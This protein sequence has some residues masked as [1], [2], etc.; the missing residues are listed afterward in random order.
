ML[1]LRQLTISRKLWLL[2]T[3]TTLGLLAIAMISLQQNHAD[4]LQEKQF[5][6]RMLVETAHSI[7][8]AAHEQ[9]SLGLIS[10][11]EARDRV[12]GWPW[13]WFFPRMVRTEDVSMCV[14]T[15]G[16]VRFRMK[17]YRGALEDLQE[18]VD[19]LPDGSNYLYLGLAYLHLNEI[20]AAREAARKAQ[21][22]RVVGEYEEFLLNHLIEQLGGI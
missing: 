5:Q 19:L 7:L 17:D 1:I 21:A 18:A 9:A 16:W 13:T 14:N 10:M 6:T 3:I 8:A 4:M 15:R 22:A 2:T 20:P 11:A 12:S